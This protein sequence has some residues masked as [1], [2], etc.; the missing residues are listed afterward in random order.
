VVLG[1]PVRV[2]WQRDVFRPGPGFRAMCSG[3]DEPETPH[4]RAVGGKMSKVSIPSASIGA[5]V[6][7]VGFILLMAPLVLLAML[8]FHLHPGPAGAI[9]AALRGHLALFV[10]L[11]LGGGVCCAFGG[12]V[13]A[14]I[15]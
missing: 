11:A 3:Q 2:D 10:A 13:T 1:N 5:M 8:R 9:A 12:Y 4:G 14:W 6:D 15:V 7:V